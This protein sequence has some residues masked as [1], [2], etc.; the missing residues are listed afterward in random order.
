LTLFPPKPCLQFHIHRCLGRCVQG[1]TTDEAYA[2]AVRD[3]RLFLEGRHTD[4]ARGLRVR[5]QAAS[6]EM[7]FEEAAG[8]RD[9]IS[10]VE[11]IDERQKMAAAKGDDVDIFAVYAEPPLVAL[12][13][14][15]LRNGQIVDRRELFCADH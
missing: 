8:L 4:L 10:T 2:A 6:D 14:F 15:H 9:L 3:V 12:N 13:L 11:E 1:L 5:M 7:R